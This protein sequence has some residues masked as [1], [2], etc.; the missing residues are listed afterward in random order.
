LEQFVSLN[1]GRVTDRY[2]GT[3]L[4]LARIRVLGTLLDQLLEIGDI[5]EIDLPPEPAMEMPEYRYTQL[6]DFPNPVTPPDPDSP[7]VCVIDSG[8]ATGHPFL[9]A[10]VGDARAFPVSLGTEIDLSLFGL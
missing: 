8:L 7:G 4:Y 10:A 3:D 1:G 6:D 2:R 9:N 5:R